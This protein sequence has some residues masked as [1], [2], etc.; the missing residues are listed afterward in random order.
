MTVD[1]DTQNELIKIAKR[2]RALA[3]AEKGGADAERRSS[4]L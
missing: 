4:D 1:A 3:D 2:H